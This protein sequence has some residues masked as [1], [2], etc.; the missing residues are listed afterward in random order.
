MGPLL[1]GVVKV[2]FPSPWDKLAGESDD[3]FVDRMYKAFLQPFE[4][5]LPAEEVA[6]IVIEPIQGDGGII[7]VP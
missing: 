2:P 5:Y 7:K 1:P 3:Q 4:T 6:A